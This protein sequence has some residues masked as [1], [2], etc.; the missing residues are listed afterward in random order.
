MFCPWRSKITCLTQ[1]CAS[2]NHLCTNCITILY[3]TLSRW[4]RTWAFFKACRWLPALKFQQHRN[5]VT[6][7]SDRKSYQLLTI[8]HFFFCG[9]AKFQAMLL[10][11]PVMKMSWRCQAPSSTPWSWNATTD[12]WASPFLAPRS[13]LTPL[14]SPASP[15]KAWRRGERA[16]FR[17]VGGENRRRYFH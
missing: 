2:H 9:P 12:P 17:G 11:L 13:L 14:W 16:A 15:R 6:L 7:F 3:W 10:L 8:V 1:K 5:H 4:I